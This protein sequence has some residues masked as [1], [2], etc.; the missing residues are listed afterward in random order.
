MQRLLHTPSALLV[1]RLLVLYG[2]LQLC[3]VLFYTYNHLT[4]GPIGWAEAGTLAGGSLRFDTRSILYAD[5]LFVLLSLLPFEFCCSRW[6]QRL[7]FWY[8]TVVNFVLIIVVNLADAVRF[9]LAQ[10]RFTAADL[11]DIDFAAL[12]G[13]FRTIGENWPLVLAAL[14]LLILLT[15]SFGRCDRCESILNPGW[16]YYIFSTLLF[17]GVGTLCVAGFR[18]G[19][20]RNAAPLAPADAAC[21]TAY[22][23]KAQLIMS[24]PFYLVGEIRWDIPAKPADGQPEQEASSSAS[25]PAVQAPD[26]QHDRPLKPEQEEGL[27]RMRQLQPFLQP[28]QQ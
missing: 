28:Q 5:A 3:R 2:I 9:H 1:R 18:G 13:L 10:Q 25:E 11:F 19:F 20:S 4:I 14:A 23:G 27:H 22:A 21:Y 16:S 6:Y 17:F 12:P 24:N 7:L 15:S 8:Y 26:L